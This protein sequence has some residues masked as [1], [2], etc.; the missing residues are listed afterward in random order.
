MSALPPPAPPEHLRPPS[1]A[2]VA[3]AAGT[4]LT[5]HN[6]QMVQARKYMKNVGMFQYCFNGCLFLLMDELQSLKD[7][8]ECFVLF[9]L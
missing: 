1:S 8:C 9:S 6:L 2:A 4:P 5:H 7:Y 3:T